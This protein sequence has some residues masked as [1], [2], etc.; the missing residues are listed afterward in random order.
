MGFRFPHEK[1]QFFGKRAPIIKYRD[2]LPWAVQKRLN[3]SICRLGFGL[4][5]AERS[6]SLIVFVR[7]RQCAHM[8]RHIGGTW[9]TRLNCLS[10]AA[11]RSYVKLFWP[12]VNRFCR[13][14]VDNTNTS[15]GDVAQNSQICNWHRKTLACRIRENSRPTGSVSG[16]LRPGRRQTLP[17]HWLSCITERPRDAPCH[18]VKFI[19]YT[20]WPFITADFENVIQFA[21][22]MVKSVVK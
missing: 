12:L 9:W 22:I 19:L 18:L 16:Q 6:T 1:W 21:T 4:G 20:I 13:R 10:A 14:L 17:W 2:F 7:R 5:L 15:W 3:R 8:G 11:M